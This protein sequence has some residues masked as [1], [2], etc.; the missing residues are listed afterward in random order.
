MAVQYSKGSYKKDGE[1]LFTKAC[2][3][4]TRGN[5]FKLKEGE[6]RLDIRETYFVI[7]VM[8]HS[9]G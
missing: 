4:W 5:G 2:S 7:R 1:R 8:K 3:D 9:N 6:F